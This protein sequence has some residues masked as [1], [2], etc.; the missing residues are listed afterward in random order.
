MLSMFYSLSHAQTCPA[1]SIT[2]INSGNLSAAGNTY[3]RAGQATVNAGSSSIVLGP[4]DYG[5][6]SISPLDI[7]LIIQMQGAEI[8][9]SNGGAYG[10]NGTAGR[11]Y[12]INSQ[13]MAGS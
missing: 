11:G 5:S 10:S 12:L 9:F 2:P 8:N 6:T 1:S 4:A 13:L 7:L 3:F